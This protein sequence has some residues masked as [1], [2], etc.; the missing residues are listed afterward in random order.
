[1][2]IRKTHNRQIDIMRQRDR[3]TSTEREKERESEREPT[4]IKTKRN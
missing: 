1:M 4:N 2:N 3:Q